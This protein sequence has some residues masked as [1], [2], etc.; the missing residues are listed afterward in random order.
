MKHCH[1][2]KHGVTTKRLVRHVERDNYA[3]ILYRIVKKV[4]YREHGKDLVKLNSLY[5]IGLE[6]ETY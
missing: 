3:M 1:R 6:A 4:L 5:T 2:A